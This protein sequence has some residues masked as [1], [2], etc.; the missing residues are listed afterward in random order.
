MNRIMAIWT[1]LVDRIRGLRVQL[2]LGLRMSVAAV[3]TY[4]LSQA[5]AP[6]PAALG[7]LTSVIVTQ[8]SVGKSLKATFDYME[9]ALGGAIY[10][11][12]VSTLFPHAG[13]IA[14]TAMLA[15]A[16]AP[17]AATSSRRS[18]SA[19]PFSTPN[20]TRNRW[21]TRCSGCAMISS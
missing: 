18:G 6:S 8:I 14:I 2:R 4:V 20:P 7:V 16:V 11:G 1:W 5:F 3:L 21:S 13:S 10:R 17:L 12:A 15:L 9:G 19:C